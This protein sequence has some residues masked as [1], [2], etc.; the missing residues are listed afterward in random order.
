MY[1]GR[2]III[3]LFNFLYVQTFFCLHT[4]ISPY[5]IIITN[6]LFVLFII[7]WSLIIIIDNLFIL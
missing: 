2:I 7:T 1:V 6:L 4:S 3:T 5:W